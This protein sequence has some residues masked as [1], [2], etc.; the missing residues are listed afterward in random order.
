MTTSPSIKIQTGKIVLDYDSAFAIKSGFAVERNEV[1][2]MDLVSTHT[3]I[4]SPKVITTKIGLSNGIIDM[5]LMPG[6]S[7]EKRW[8]EMNEDTKESVCRQLWTMISQIRDIPRPPELV[9]GSF[10]CMVDGSPTR[11]LLL[12]D[13]DPGSPQPLMSGSDIR[14]RIYQRYLYFGG[15][16]YKDQLPDMLPRADCSVFTH[17]Y[18]APRNIMVDEEGLVTGIVD[19]ETAGWYPDYWEYAQIM[20]PAVKCADWSAWMEKM[21]PKKWDVKGINAARKVL[22]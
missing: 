12:E 19:W 3:S 14:D 18:I 5:T 10:Q 17:G 11:S 13:L 21:A 16:L 9:D 22:F 6:S 1:E 15:R 8:D 4:P 2:A 20:R 7:L